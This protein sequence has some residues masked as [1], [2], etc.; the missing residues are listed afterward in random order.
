VIEQLGPDGLWRATATVTTTPDGRFSRAVRA[1]SNTTYRARI[2]ESPSDAA[3]A[4]T[5]T[6]LIVRRGISLAGA[7]ASVVRVVARSVATALTAVLAPVGPDVAVTVLISRR[8][9]TGT[10]RTV[11]RLAGLSSGGRAVFQWR[12]TVAGSY[13]VRLA[14]APTRDFANGLSAAYRFTV[15]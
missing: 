10:Y 14:T 12:P 9:A 5:T 13:V 6:R 2:T 8:D 3:A 15:R 11:T 1:S 4:S 7:P